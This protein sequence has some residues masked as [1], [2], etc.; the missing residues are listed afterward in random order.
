LFLKAYRLTPAMM[1][2]QKKK[3][4]TPEIVKE[5]KL[6]YENFLEELPVVVKN[7]HLVNS[8]LCELQDMSPSSKRYNFLDLSTRL[9]LMK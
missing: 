4:F 1:E 5:L 6:N 8:L 7:S 9:N 2:M 3:E